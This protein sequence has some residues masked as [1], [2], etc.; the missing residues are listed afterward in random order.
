MIVMLVNTWEGRDVATS[1]VSGA[2]LYTNMEDYTLL[3][4]EGD[5]VTIMC[6]VNKDYDFFVF[7]EN[8]K[9]FLYLRL[10]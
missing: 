2:Y 5:T 7:H 10:L 1:N 3:K 9:K 6:D 4:L 8:R